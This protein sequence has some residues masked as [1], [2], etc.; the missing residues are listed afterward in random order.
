MNG[1]HY[2]VR[3]D[4]AI[5]SKVIYCL[6]GINRDGIKDLLGMYIKPG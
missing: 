2:K 4:N 3:V 1:I 6:I 5:K